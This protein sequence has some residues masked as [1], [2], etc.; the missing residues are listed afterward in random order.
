MKHFR[1][2]L[3]SIVALILFGVLVLFFPYSIKG[4]PEWR[5]KIVDQNGAPAVGAQVE[6]EWIDPDREG[7]GTLMD[8]KVVG[9]DGLVVFPA[10]RLHNRLAN[11][12]RFTASTHA[13]ACWNGQYGDSYWYGGPRPLSTVLKLKAV[14]VCPYG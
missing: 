7:A 6:Q 10:H 8:T 12:K 5:L 11:L 13:Y 9:P 14:A 4:V 1:K 3:A 2:V